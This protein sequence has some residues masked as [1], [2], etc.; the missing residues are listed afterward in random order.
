MRILI[1]GIKFSVV[2]FSPLLRGLH[3]FWCDFISNVGYLARG[4]AL[5]VCLLLVCWISSRAFCPFV[6][7]GIFCA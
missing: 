4:L 3:I 5:R 2:G 1:F 7:C 6:G